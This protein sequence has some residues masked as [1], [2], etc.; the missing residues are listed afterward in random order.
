[1]T[2]LSWHGST[3]IMT[4]YQMVWC[5]NRFYLKLW[6]TVVNQGIWFR[7]T[8]SPKN[9]F[10]TGAEMNEFFSYYKVEKHKNICHLQPNACN[11]LV[12]K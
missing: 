12:D 2:S 3:K 7:G 10:V 6:G 5:H 4:S 1:M 8:L 11:A 9:R